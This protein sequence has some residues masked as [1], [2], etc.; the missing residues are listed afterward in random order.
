MKDKLQ[1][2]NFSSKVSPVNNMKKIHKD[3]NVQVYLNKQKMHPCNIS[4]ILMEGINRQPSNQYEAIGSMRQLL[5]GGWNI[6]PQ[7]N[8]IF[9]TFFPN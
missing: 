1:H 4:E 7:L 6:F 5:L 8:T 3:E 2:N 9:N